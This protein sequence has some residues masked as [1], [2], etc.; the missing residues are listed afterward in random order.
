M[1]E[2]VN[3]QPMVHFYKNDLR[4]WKWKS[5]GERLKEL[6]L[7]NLAKKQIRQRPDSVQ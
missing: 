1:I 6:N 2:A 3:S 4:A 7:V 5:C